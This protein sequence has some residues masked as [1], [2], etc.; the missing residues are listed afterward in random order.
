MNFGINSANIFSGTSNHTAKATNPMKQ[1]YM[2]S[3]FNGK[4]PTSFDYSDQKLQRPSD[5][6]N[7]YRMQWLG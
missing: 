3:A 6:N 5:S 1:E 7:D 2:N 4:G